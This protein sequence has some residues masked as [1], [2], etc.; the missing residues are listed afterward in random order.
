MS[1]TPTSSLPITQTQPPIKRLDGW[2]DARYI[3]ELEYVV[4]EQRKLLQQ[5]SQI[6]ALLAQGNNH[7]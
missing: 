3:I 7:E 1:N 6:K 4:Y 2:T 5:F